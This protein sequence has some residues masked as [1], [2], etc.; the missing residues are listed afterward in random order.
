MTVTLFG[1]LILISIDFYF[2]LLFSSHCKFWLRIYMYIK[3]SRQCLTTF[4]KLIKNTLLHIVFG[5]VVK[6]GL[7]C[8]IYC[9]SCVSAIQLHHIQ[10]NNYWD[11][12]SHTNQ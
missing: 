11:T 6:H 10:T 9:F 3:H 7:L 1:Y 4:P 2:I 8:S 5:N 12:T